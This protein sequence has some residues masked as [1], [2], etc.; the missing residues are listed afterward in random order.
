[1]LCEINKDAFSSGQ[2][3]SKIWL[4]E[5]AEKL[6]SNIDCIWIYG[7]WYGITAFLL[8]S[9]GNIK[10]KSIRSFDIDPECEAI[11]DIINENWVWRNWQFKAHTQDCNL[12]NPNIDN[13]PDI[14][15]NTST[16]HFECMDWWD[17]IPKGKAVILQ[18][19]N[20]QHEDHYGNSDS[21]DAFIKTF[22]VSKLI[23]SGQRD[24]NYGSWGFSRYMLIGVK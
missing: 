17:N 18:G 20:M 16:E 11:A 10:I 3:T 22:P 5:E 7:G 21:L 15:I 23:Y 9:R 14:I 1:M 2:V 19:N 8:H 12:L 24:F 6:F 13:G 4:C